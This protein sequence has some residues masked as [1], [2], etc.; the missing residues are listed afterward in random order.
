MWSLGH[1]NLQIGGRNFTAV[2]VKASVDH[3]PSARGK[4]R[5][6][7]LGPGRSASGW[8]TEWRTTDDKVDG[9]MFAA[10]AILDL[11]IGSLAME[12]SSNGPSL[13]A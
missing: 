9:L 13:I 12:N 5:A 1:P 10:A 7:S 11:S 4:H 2:R 6:V 3:V 8:N